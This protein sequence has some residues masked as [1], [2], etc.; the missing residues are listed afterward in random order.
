MALSTT[1]TLESPCLIMR[2]RGQGDLSPNDDLD[3]VDT[4]DLRILLQLARQT[5]YCIET[6]LAARS[7]LSRLPTSVRNCIE[8]MHDTIQK[9]D[10]LQRLDDTAGLMSTAAKIM[11]NEQTGRREKIYKQF[12]IDI[13]DHCG[14]STTLLCAKSLGKRRIVDL[15]IRE[16]ISL[17]SY[18]KNNSKT[19]Q[20]PVLDGLALRLGVTG[21]HQ[22]VVERQIE[23]KYSEASIDVISMLGPDLANAVQ[24]SNQYKWERQTGGSTTDCIQGLTPRNRGDI[25]LQLLLGFDEGTEVMEELEMQVV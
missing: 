6:E 15:N 1:P 22:S 11:Q 3:G 4:G 14:P 23:Y 25:T 21:E 7:A 2:T 24:A 19:F 10:V 12:L 20:H 5:T 16:R 9:L 18:L 17:L 13:R 8:K